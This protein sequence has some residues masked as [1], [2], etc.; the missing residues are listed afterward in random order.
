M[1]CPKCNDEVM[2]YF[3]FC[4][5]C[6]KQLYDE[7]VIIYFQGDDNKEKMLER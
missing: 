7:P 4:P 3:N 1:K 5:N 6:G 2:F